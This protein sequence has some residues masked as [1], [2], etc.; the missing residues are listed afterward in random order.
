EGAE[1]AQF[2]RGS[3]AAAE[4][5]GEHPPL[6]AAAEGSVL[7]VMVEDDQIAGLRLDGNAGH[8]AAGDAIPQTYYPDPLS[9]TSCD[10]QRQQNVRPLLARERCQLAPRPA[11]TPAPVDGV[12]RRPGVPGAR[13]LTRGR[14]AASLPLAGRTAAP[15]GSCA[16]CSSVS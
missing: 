13:R 12:P 3:S 14:P 7:Q 4:V 16:S 5:E 1:L 2:G 9:I 6:V 8:V 15:S 10:P 11:A